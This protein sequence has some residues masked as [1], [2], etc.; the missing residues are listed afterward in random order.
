MWIYDL[1][2][3]AVDGLFFRQICSN[4]DALLKFQDFV[5][6]LM[7]NRPLLEPTILPKNDVTS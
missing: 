7:H 4:E 2:L 5:F 6:K 3:Q 1:V